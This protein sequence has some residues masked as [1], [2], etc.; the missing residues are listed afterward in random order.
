MEFRSSLAHW[1]VWSGYLFVLFSDK[2][3]Y[4]HAAFHYEF[5]ILD[6]T[7]IFVSGIRHIFLE[8][9]T[10]ILVLFEIFFCQW[11]LKMSIYFG[12]DACLQHLVTT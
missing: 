10:Q 11:F 12:Q 5:H 9:M 2:A 8:E 6:D 3:F 1:C 4:R 7:T